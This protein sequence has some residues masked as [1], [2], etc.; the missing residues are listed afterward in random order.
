MEVWHNTIILGTGQQF[1]LPI[2]VDVAQVGG[3]VRVYY[4]KRHVLLR[5]QSLDNIDG[6]PTVNQ[7]KILDIIAVL[8]VGGFQ[9]FDAPD[10]R[11]RVAYVLVLEQG[12]E[13]LAGTD[14]VDVVVDH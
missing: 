12:L 14:A 10:D 4:K 7:Y 2:A 9:I 1:N 5:F 6:A 13:D 3:S 11:E 8:P